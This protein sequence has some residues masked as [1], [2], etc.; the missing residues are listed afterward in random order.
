MNDTSHDNLQ[1]DCQNCFGLC[2]VALYFAASEGFPSDKEA[3]Q[4]CPDLQTDFRC[5]VHKGLW[6]KGL[7]G[8]MAFD[9]FGAGQ[10]TWQ[11][12]ILCS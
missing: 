4:P 3:G 8:C 1:A 10:N 5:R 12:L 11:M 6:E 9:C 7:K 2:C